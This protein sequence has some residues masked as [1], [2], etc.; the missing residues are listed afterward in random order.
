MFNMK[1]HKQYIHI[2]VYWVWL[3]VQKPLSS[4]VAG[5]STR[6]SKKKRQSESGTPEALKKVLLGKDH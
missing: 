1:F 6:S 4:G 3:N 2:L 5:E